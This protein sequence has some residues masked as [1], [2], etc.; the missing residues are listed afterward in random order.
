MD[1]KPFGA[2]ITVV[3]GKLCSEMPNTNEYPPVISHILTSPYPLCC[4]NSNV[5]IATIKVL[6]KT[7]IFHSSNSFTWSRFALKSTE[8]AKSESLG[9]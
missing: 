7:L 6:V 5:F 3:F 4:N 9:I 1:C 2:N 8:H